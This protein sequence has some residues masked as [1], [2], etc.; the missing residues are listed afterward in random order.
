MVRGIGEINL[1]SIKKEKKLV[2]KKFEELS[3]KIFFNK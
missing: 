3:S 2:L 1:I